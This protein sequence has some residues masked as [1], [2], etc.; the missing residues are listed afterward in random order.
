MIDIGTLGFILRA[1]LIAQITR[2]ARK[3]QQ[4]FKKI[5]TN[6]HTE[7]VYLIRM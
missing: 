7:Y 6:T 2:L 5:P 1:L 4:K 3:I